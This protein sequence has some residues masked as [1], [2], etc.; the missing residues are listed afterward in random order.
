MHLENGD[1]RTF[2]EGMVT[3][4]QSPALV[5]LDAHW[6]GSPETHGVEGECPLLGELEI[7]A[8][9]PVEHFILI[10][11]ARLFLAPPD[12]PHDFRAWPSIRDVL[13]SPCLRN[14]RYHVDIEDDVITAVPAGAAE[15]LVRFRR[16]ARADSS[17]R[18][19]SRGASEIARGVALIRRGL[20]RSLA[21]AARGALTSPRSR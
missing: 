9:A 2:L 17:E 4:L 8:A 18:Y 6:C 19:F 13:T 14:E 3:R 20:R 11:D 15:W 5:W 12:Q 1:T 16:A 21:R 7:L 10:D